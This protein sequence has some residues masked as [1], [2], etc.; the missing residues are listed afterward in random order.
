MCDGWS[1]GTLLADLGALYSAQVT[2]MAAALP[3]AASYVDYIRE[4]AGPAA[5]RERRAAEEY[6]LGCYA[7][8]VPELDLPADHPRPPVKTY[9]GAQD[10]RDVEAS[11][12]PA[13]KRLGARHGCTSFVTLLA[14]FQALV[15]RLTGQTDFVIGIPFAG[16]AALENGHLVGHCVQTLPLR[17]RVDPESSFAEHLVAVRTALLDAQ[18]HRALT[19]GTL[20]RRLKL[21]RDPSR[22]PLVGIIFNVDRMGALPTFAR[23]AVEPIVPPK[24]FVNFELSLNLVD[25]DGRL[26]IESS[27]NTDLFEPET[28]RRWM[29]HFV[30]LLEGAAA[31]PKTAIADLPVLSDRERQGVLVGWNQTGA[32]LPAEPAMHRLF[33]AQVRRTPAATAVVDGSTRLTYEQL[34]R[35]ANRI[36]RRLRALG[37]RPE[38]LVGVCLERSANMLAALLG[39]LK[40]GGAYLPLDPAYPR[41]RFEFMLADAGAVLLITQESLRPRV[42]G[43]GT[44]VLSLDGDGEALEQEGDTDLDGDAGGP[45]LAYVIYTSGSTGRPKGVAIEHG[46]AVALIGWA[47]SVYSASELSGVLA[48][49]SICFDLSVFEMF[50]PLSLGGKVVVADSAL[51]LPR[52]AAADEVTLVN[53]V[54]SVMAE[55][56]RGGALPLSVVTVNLAGEPLPTQ[57]VDRL[58]EQPGVTKVYDLYGPTEDTTYSTFTRRRS[59]EPPTIGR[60]ISNSQAY[61]LDGRR[62]P[63]PIGVV[64]ELYLGGAGVARGYLNRPELTEERFVPDLFSADPGARMY[65]TGDLARWRADGCLEYL[66]RSDHQVKLRGFRIELGEIEAALALHP[67]VREV[68][69]LVRQDGDDEQR[70]LVAYVATDL[71][72]AATVLRDHLRTRLPEFMVPAHF[73]VVASLGRTVNGKVDR[74]ALPAPSRPDPRPV[75]APPRNPAEEVV[76]RIWR[77]ILRRPEVDIQDNFFELGGDSLMAARMMNRL[78]SAFGVHLPLRRLFEARTLAA[79][80]ELADAARWVAVTPPVAPALGPGA[81]DREEVEL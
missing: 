61:V 40:A 20:V 46:N 78:Q 32:P 14:G 26:V 19:F 27:Y 49:T 69:V 15:H 24:S 41:D 18:T 76:A 8:A 81:R 38:N 1:S 47:G 23:L 65:R 67:A 21:P 28:I 48:A 25:A 7:D 51:E 30:V 73:V 52:I 55:L 44:S 56:L 37:V 13:L 66:G 4:T 72:S 33:E 9:P 2:G 70:L 16:Q 36:A 71:A 63:V 60:S 79:L 77:E 62:R 80:A 22:T 50:V 68:A 10:N 17:C 3:A 53:T 11:L 31:D 34:N 43:G 59:G 12:Y 74:Q 75:S 39:V 35:Q 64:G 57:L 42:A 5:E 54:P 6:W 45:S 29:G 58:Y